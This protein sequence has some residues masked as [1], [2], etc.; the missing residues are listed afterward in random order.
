MPNYQKNFV[1][2]LFCKDQFAM[3]TGATWASKDRG[4]NKD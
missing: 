2:T 3:Q 1:H 4:Q